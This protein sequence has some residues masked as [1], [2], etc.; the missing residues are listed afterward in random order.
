LYPTSHGA[1]EKKFLTR[2]AQHDGVRDEQ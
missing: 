2:Q 1:K